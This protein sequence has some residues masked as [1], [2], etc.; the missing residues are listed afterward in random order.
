ML[1]TD[2]VG[3]GKGMKKKTK[4]SPRLIIGWREWL[5]FPD[6]G[7]DRIKAK[8]DTGARTSAIHAFDIREFE[9]DGESYV[10]FLVHPAQRRKKPEIRCS[11]RVREKRMIT[12]SNGARSERYIIE[13]QL[14]IGGHFWPIELSLAKRDQLGFRVLL[15]RQA[16]R[17]KCIIDAGSSY[18]IGKRPA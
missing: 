17:G 1:F 7:I 9:R 4:I 5:S 15:G 14:G 12:S 3:I 8:I 2:Q 16:I 6:L 11:A 13:T 18:K 10:E